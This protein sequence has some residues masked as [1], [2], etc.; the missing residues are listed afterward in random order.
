LFSRQR[1]WSADPTG[2]SLDHGKPI[3]AP[4]DRGEGPGAMAD[5]AF[6]LVTL[7]SFVL[8]ALAVKAVAR[9]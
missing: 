3:R 9:L 6:V 2:T 1:P 4:T 8:L 7:A 5:V